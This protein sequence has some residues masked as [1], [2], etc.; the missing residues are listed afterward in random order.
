MAE[1]N[2]PNNI[3]DMLLKMDRVNTT[4]NALDKVVNAESVKTADGKSFADTL[5]ET[6]SQTNQLQVE[7]DQ[8]IVD[9]ASEENPD[10]HETMIAIQKADVSFQMIME[11]R[12]KI[13]KAYEEVMRTQI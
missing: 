6:I 8:A 4:E 7:A 2:F 11:V 1:I 5:K 10:I 3:N 9:F 12:N 13:L